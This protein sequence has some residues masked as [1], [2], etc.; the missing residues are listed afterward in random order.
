[1]DKQTLFDILHKELPTEITNLP[2]ICIEDSSDFIKRFLVEN[3]PKTDSKN[4]TTD[5]KWNFLLEKHSFEKK[6]KQLKGKKSFLTRRQR[7]NLNLHK[8][9]KQGWN[10]GELDT[11]R[12]M[13]KSY[14]REN[15]DMVEVP[16]YLDPNWNAFSMV[17]AKSELVGAELTIIKSRVPSL[18]RMTG[19]VVLET[20]MTFQIVTPKSQLKVLLKDGSVFEFSLD[21]MK[22]TVYG[23]YLITKP[24]ERSVKKIKSQMVP[25]I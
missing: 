16:N 7:I 25:Y 12:Q 1:M 17:L 6:K 19:T 5:L 10:Y 14:M 8:L 20:K 21:D 24:S 23:K 18:I 13:W 2:P 22:F 9:P 3:L 11:L 4:V 15:I